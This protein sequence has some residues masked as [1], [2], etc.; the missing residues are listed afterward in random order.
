MISTGSPTPDLWHRGS[1][2]TE[3]SGDIFY[4]EGGDL[5]PDPW[6]QALDEWD[7]Q[8]WQEWQ[9]ATDWYNENYLQGYDDWENYGAYDDGAGGMPPMT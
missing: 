5:H 8:E 6:Q 7:N 3:P 2:R 1:N 4:G 9:D